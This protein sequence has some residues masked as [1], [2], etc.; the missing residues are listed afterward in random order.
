MGDR[1]RNQENRG[2][3]NAEQ[4][5]KAYGDRGGIG[6]RSASLVEL[7]GA[8][9][10]SQRDYGYEG[11]LYVTEDGETYDN[12]YMNTHNPIRTGVNFYE[13]SNWRYNERKEMYEP[14]I[15]RIVMIKIRFTEYQ[16]SLDL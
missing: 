13:V 7:I 8:E 10:V 2:H 12:E 3:I 6:D 16:L 9:R 14:V 1:I 11:T 15:R 4:N 5:Y